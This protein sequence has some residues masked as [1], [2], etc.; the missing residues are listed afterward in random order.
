MKTK[1][2]HIGFAAT[3]EITQEKALGDICSAE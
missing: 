1:N 3:N 2:V